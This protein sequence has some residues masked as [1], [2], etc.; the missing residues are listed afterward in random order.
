VHQV[1]RQVHE[2][3]A[4]EQRL[5][6]Q[7]E[8]EALEVAQAAVDELRRAARRAG[9]IV[10]ALDESHAV[11]ARR[12]VERDARAGDPAAD[13]DHVEAVRPEGAQCLVAADHGRYVT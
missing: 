5:A 3:R 12:R 9:R 7:P 4:L 1:R 10:L 2:Q 13:H 11:A 6:H 8:V